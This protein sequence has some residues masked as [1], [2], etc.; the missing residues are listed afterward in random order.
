MKIHMP[1]VALAMGTLLI[2]GSLARADGEKR[3]AR[4]Q[5]AFSSLRGLT[6]EEARDQSLAWLKTAGK[7]DAATIQTFE[8][9]WS[10]NERA[11]V[12]RV[13]DTLALTDADAQKLLADARNPAVAAPTAVP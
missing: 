3:A 13:A 6:P 1:F 9:I 7:T 11:V 12:D 4:E 2:G 5:V 8:T 10:A